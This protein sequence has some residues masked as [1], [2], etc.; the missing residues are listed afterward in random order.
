[1][2]FGIAHLWL[3]NYQTAWE[4]FD[5]AN[6]DHPK[7]MSGFYAKAGVAKWCLDESEEAVNQWRIGLECGY[8]DLGRVHLPLLLFIASV[9]K[10]Q[11]FSRTEAEAILTARLNDLDV[12]SWPATLVGFVLGRIDEQQLR[13]LGPRYYN[14]IPGWPAQFH[15][16][17][18]FYVGI[19][20]YSHGNAVGFNKAMRKA[21][22]ISWDE[23]EPRGGLFLSKLWA[24]EFFIAR[25]EARGHG[26]TRS[27]SRA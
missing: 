17:A 8:A 18:D 12:N 26:K 27:D 16:L 9:I 6:R 21:A 24:E 15:W 11:V 19:V 4:H 1:M 13:T 20:D 3:G 5:R 25:H 10:P 22:L 14:W 2:E 23:Y 7:S